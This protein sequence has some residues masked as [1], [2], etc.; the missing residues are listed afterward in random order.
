MP[1][2]QNIATTKVVGV[3]L[4]MN[5]KSIWQ[6]SPSLTPETNSWPL[7]VTH[8]LWCRVLKRKITQIGDQICSEAIIDKGNYACK[9]NSVC[10][11]YDNGPGYWCSC[12]NGFEG[13]PYHK[14]GCQGYHIHFYIKYIIL[15]V[16]VFWILFYLGWITGYFFFLNLLVTLCP[17]YIDEC[18]NSTLCVQKCIDFAGTY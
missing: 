16:I 3:Y 6:S 13:N 10:H 17:P 11:G 7:V 12:I 15:L 2:L 4:I 18:Q 1:K 8:S 5:V 9:N 14:N